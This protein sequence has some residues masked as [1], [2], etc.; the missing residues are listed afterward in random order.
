M[1]YVIKFYQDNKLMKELQMESD[2]IGNAAKEAI[3]T[4]TGYIH[5]NRI[6]VEKL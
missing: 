5:W 6:K 4:V 2:D 3:D 1:T